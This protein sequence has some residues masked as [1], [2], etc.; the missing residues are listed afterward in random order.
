MV[1]PQEDLPQTCVGLLRRIR[2]RAAEVGWRSAVHELRSVTQDLWRGAPL[3]ERHRFLRHLRPW[4]DV[5]RHRVAPAVGATIDRM[6]AD[7]R[8]CFTAG[9]IAAIRPDGE[10]ACLEWRPRGSGA[11][12]QIS[13]RRIVNCT[14]PE[15]DIV[16][17]G[18][19]LFDALIGRGRIRPDVCR[20]GIDVDGE[21]RA[22]GAD[23]RPSER[24]FAIGPMTR[25]AF[26][27]SIAVPDIR[28]QAARIAE[29][30]TA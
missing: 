18:E 22:I 1:A 26:W 24:L 13:A 28:G 2:R 25:G 11:V 8:L 4:W 3:E 30:L 20:I 29:R 27:E 21:M 7:G 6:Q 15:L 17:A 16:R 5:H 12:E 14:G 10:G 9:S 23:G 19:P